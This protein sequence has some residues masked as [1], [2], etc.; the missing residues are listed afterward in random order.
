ME[1][2]PT[3]RPEKNQNKTPQKRAPPKKKKKKKKKKKLRICRSKE[4][5]LC[6]GE[7]AYGDKYVLQRKGTPMTPEGGEISPHTPLTG[8]G[9][10]EPQPGRT[11]EKPKRI[12]GEKRKGKVDVSRPQR[13]KRPE[14]PRLGSMKKG[15]SGKADW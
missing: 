13:G 4:T 12:E 9:E 11:V 14:I 10:A 6:T 15:R 5:I 7:K 1:A 2:R 8:H 3:L